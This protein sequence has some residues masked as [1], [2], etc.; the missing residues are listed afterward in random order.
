MRGGCGPPRAILCGAGCIFKARIVDKNGK[1]MQ[2][3]RPI[4]MSRNTWLLGGGGGGVN[5]SVCS[6]V[7]IINALT[8][9]VDS[10]IPNPRV[11]AMAFLV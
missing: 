7:F 8:S 1:I 10:Y 11:H 9:R 6:F 3:T 5:N 4:L 2:C